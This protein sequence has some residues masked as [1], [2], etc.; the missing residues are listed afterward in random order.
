[1]KKNLRAGYSLITVIIIF[2]V[3]AFLGYLGVQKAIDSTIETGKKQYEGTPIQA[4]VDG[5]MQAMR[6][7]HQ[8]IATQGR[9]GRLSSKATPTM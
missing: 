3:L 4:F 8:N 1:M 5:D 7:A 6:A 2:A 9:C